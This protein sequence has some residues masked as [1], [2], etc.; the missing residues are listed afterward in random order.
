MIS[1]FSA[2]ALQS[3]GKIIAVGS[4]ASARRGVSNIAI[5]RYLTDGSLDTTF[6]TD[7]I[8]T[9]SLEVRT[10]VVPPVAIQP[11]GKIVVAGTPG[12]NTFPESWAVLRYNTD[13]TPDTSFGES[14]RVTTAFE[15]F[16]ARPVA[17]VIQSNGRILVGGSGYVPFSIDKQL[18]FIFS[19][20]DPDGTL[21]K[22]FGEEGLAYSISSVRTDG[23]TGMAVQPDGKIVATGSTI[24]F[25]Q[26]YDWLVSR[27]NGDG[28]VDAS[29]GSG[30]KVVTDMGRLDTSRAVAVWPNGKI[31][32]AGT[33]EDFGFEGTHA[34]IAV[35]RYN[36]DGS[37]DKTFGEDGSVT[38]DLGKTEDVS[39]L[40]CRIDG[41]IHV[42]GSISDGPIQSPGSS[43]FL[44]VRYNSDGS[45]DTRFGSDGILTT[46]FGKQEKATSI[47][48]MD[49]KAPSIT[50][51][52]SPA[53]RS[54]IAISKLRKPTRRRRGTARSRMRV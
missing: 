36:S 31:V 11:N 41:K 54:G 49:R 43:D 35:A 5:V 2:V 48:A 32:V 14:G 45:R 50:R 22:S 29:F 33:T 30:G 39:G 20:Y 1:S 9:S 12:T 15:H 25:P 18:E 26:S 53:G 34:D 38:T 21:D 3:D 16:D 13:G 51:A 4:A 8:V 40:A 23:M 27:F 47:R 24:G 28:S 10:N 46:D 6:G 42:A 7:G 19:R 37:V 52:R 17:I 44:L